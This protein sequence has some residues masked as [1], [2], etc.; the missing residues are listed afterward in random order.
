MWDPQPPNFQFW[1]SPRFVHGQIHASY[2]L[3]IGIFLMSISTRTF[4]I[5]NISGTFV[6]RIWTCFVKEY[7]FGEQGSTNSEN[8]FQNH[9]RNDRGEILSRMRVVSYPNGHF[10]EKVILLAISFVFPLENMGL[11]V[12]SGWYRRSGLVVR[13]SAH[14]PKLHVRFPPPPLCDPCG[15]QPLC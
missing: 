5:L 6:A 8:M 14:N 15:I 9:F 3:T 1:A 7:H 4:G 10:L 13:S 11:W 2:I 12:K